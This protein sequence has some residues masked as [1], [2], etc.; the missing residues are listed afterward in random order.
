MELG[1]CRFHRL[2]EGFRI[3][4]GIQAYLQGTLI[5]RCIELR[6]CHACDN[7]VHRILQGLQCLETIERNLRDGVS[8]KGRLVDW[9]KTYT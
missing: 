5:H 7:R 1:E 3:P 4:R 6:L 8:N 9:L 2:L